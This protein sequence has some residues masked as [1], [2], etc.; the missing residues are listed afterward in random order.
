MDF[1]PVNKIKN[2]LSAS[3]ILLIVIAALVLELVSFIQYQYAK[4]EISVDLHLR[5]QSELLAKS[6]AIQNIMSQVESAVDNHVWDA[7]RQLSHPDSAYGVVKRL[8]EHNAE[9]KGSAMSFVPDYYPEEGH[10]FETYAVRRDSDQ[11]ELMQLGSQTHDYTKKEFFSIPVAM[12]SARWTEPYLDSDG[13]RMMLTTFSEPV[14][15]DSGN[16]VAVLDADISL[17]WLKTVLSEQYV[18]PSSYHILVSRSGQ[19]MSYPDQN[20]IMTKN[21]SDLA[22]EKN[23]TSF[24]E[25]AENML[26][27]ESGNII[28]N[29]SD[30]ENYHIF[31]S[32]VGGETGWSLAVVSSE[33]EIFGKFD[34]MKRNLLIFRIVAFAILIFIIVRSIRNIKKLQTVTIEKERIGSELKIAREIQMGML[35]KGDHREEENHGIDI[36]GILEPAKEVGGDLY[37]YY[38]YDDKLFFCIGDVSGKGVPAALFMTVTRSLFRN[39]SKEMIRPDKIVNQMNNTMIQTNDSN[40]F[41]TLFVGVLDLNDGKLEYCNA[42]HDAPILIQNSNLEP[43]PVIANIPV[44]IM[45]D[46]PYTKQELNM[47]RSGMLFLYTDGLTEAKNKIHKEFGEE[48]LLKDLRGIIAQN[49]DISP[50]ELMKQIIEK[51]KGFVDGAE[52]S[53]DL[54]LLSFKYGIPSRKYEVL[55]LK[56]SLDEIP[57]LNSFIQKFGDEENIEEGLLMQIKLALEEVVVN[58]MEYAYPKDET[59]QL[60]IETETSDKS[61]KFVISDYG[62][63][64]NP[65]DV[66]EADITLGLEERE[67]GGLGIFLVRQIMDKV[68]YERLGDKNILTLVKF[69]Q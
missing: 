8:V 21:I 51:V 7:E 64:F 3:G 19:I 37:D 22:K 49:N 58:V 13:A 43:I 32:P 31:Y 62:T 23:S 24:T 55:E 9:I 67:I 66:P 10:W 61:Y 29:D 33:K 16:V 42:G 56:N 50:E 69:K 41:V 44:G 20:Y 54:T 12:D 18:Y 15:D 1:N 48:R 52:Q 68:K 38:I 11:I 40:M 46:F 27:G 14:H 4:E 28:F 45:K 36:A 47:P 39:I 65:L 60:K 59:A 2:S 63:E 57:K 53:D 17:D 6:L 35:P 34:E 30:G 25:L 5:A 26:K